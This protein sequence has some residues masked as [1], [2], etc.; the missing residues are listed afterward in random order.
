MSSIKKCTW[1]ALQALL[2]ALPATV[3]ELQCERCVHL[4]I[5]TRRKGSVKNAL[6]N[7]LLSYIRAP[8]STLFLCLAN[9]V[10]YP[11]FF[12][13]LLL[14]V[15]VFIN[16]ISRELQSIYSSF[17]KHQTCMSIYQLPVKNYSFLT[18]IPQEQ[19]LICEWRS[20]T[21][22]KWNDRVST[23]QVCHCTPTQ[24]EIAS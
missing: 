3:E 15:S 9:F 19:E 22:S 5:F 24:T 23:Q 11:L 2:T 12:H 1:L 8:C 14:R 21:V 4:T 13:F 17:T 16:T 10:R 7:I 20:A 18:N 6:S